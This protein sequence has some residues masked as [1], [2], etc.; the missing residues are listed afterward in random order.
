MAC[1]R[2]AK[3][4]PP[5]PS[6]DSSVCSKC[7]FEMKSMFQMAAVARTRGKVGQATMIVPLNCPNCNTVNR[8]KVTINRTTESPR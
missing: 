2:S 5:T 7:S 6:Y 8:F 1:C 3:A 4:A